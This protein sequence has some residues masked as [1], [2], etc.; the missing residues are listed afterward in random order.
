MAHEIGRETI[1]TEVLDGHPTTVFQITIR[2]GQ[3][4]VIYYQWWAEGE[5]ITADYIHAI[6][7]TTLPG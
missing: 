4:D 2:E 1:G 6:C 5:G 7:C 3:Q